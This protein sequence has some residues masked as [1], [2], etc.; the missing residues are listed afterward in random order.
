MLT[1]AAETKTGVGL[2]DQTRRVLAY[3]HK[4]YASATS[5]AP[6]T[7]PPLTAKVLALFGLNGVRVLDGTAP[8]PVPVE[9]PDPD[10]AA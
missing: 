2:N 9:P 8:T 7:S 6:P 1:D 10:D 5:T 4:R 3:D